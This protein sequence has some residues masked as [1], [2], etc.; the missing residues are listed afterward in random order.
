MKKNLKSIITLVCICA[1]MALA[2]AVTN[3]ITAPIIKNNQDKEATKAL[4]QVMP[5]ANKFDKVDLSGYTLPATVIEA[6]KANN[7]GYVFRLKTAGYGSDFIIMCGI[8]ANG[9]VSGAVCISSNETLGHEKTFGENFKGKDAAGVD[10]VDTI[11]SATKTTAAYRSAVKDAL[12]AAI[13][14]GGGSVDIRTE[15]EI[16]ADNLKAALP[17]AN[18]EFEKHFF[19]EV[20]EGI[21]ALYVA[22]NG[23]G[24]VA[25]VGEQFIGVGADGSFTDA[26]LSEET[27]ALVSKQLAIIK[28]SVLEDVDLTNFTGISKN[29]LSAKKTATGNYV[30]DVR[31]LGYGIRG[32]YH[33]SG[34][35][36]KIR[37]SITASGKI[38]DC[39]TV[40]QSESQNSGGACADEKFY[41]Q[42]DGKTKDDYKSRE[43][44]P[45]EDK[46]NNKVF[47]SDMDAISGA[48]ITT[49]GYKQ[50]VLDAF[51]AVVIMT[52]NN[53][54]GGA[55]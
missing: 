19:V 4:I 54:E 42:F 25:V 35:Y 6:Y 40:S 51:E 16:L 28:A 27:K 53:S 13:I 48:T 55:N 22:K 50:A 1:V 11:A 9:T 44:L 2:L 31:G 45:E 37:I 10:A 29:V 43:D 17:S 47:V 21:D 15:E 12:N 30:L 49:A 5:D 32:D 46:N 24:Y 23:S 26:T 7:G 18:G 41:G 36:I 33:A 3:F 39:L 38:I 20:T 34:E 8:S 14:L 52:A